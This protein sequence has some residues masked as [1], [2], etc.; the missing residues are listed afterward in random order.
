MLAKSVTPATPVTR[1]KSHINDSYTW[2][3]QW[4]TPL[5]NSSSGPAANTK[6]K[7]W[8]K[9]QTQPADSAITISTDAFDLD[10]YIIY[11]EPVDEKPAE[12]ETPVEQ[13]GNS[14]LKSALS[15]DKREDQV[16]SLSGLGM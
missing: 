16:S 8:V 7:G 5:E 9:V 1:P 13:P 11:R 15:M 2:I 3:K 12:E 4:Y 14:D 10:K 6:L